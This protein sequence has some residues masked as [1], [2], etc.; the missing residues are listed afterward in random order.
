MVFTGHYSYLLCQGRSVLNFFWTG[1]N[2]FFVISGFVF[3]QQLNQKIYNLSFFTR[4]FFRIYP[5]YLLAL[6]SYYFLSGSEP[7]RFIYFVRHLLFMQTTSSIHE[8][9]FF[10]PA[11]W[12]LPVEIEFYILVPLLSF[13]NRRFSSLIYISIIPLL[14]LKILL[15]ANAQILPDANL[16]GILNAHLPGLILEFFL[17]VFLFRVYLFFKG[18]KV[19]T[20]VIILLQGIGLSLLFGLALFFARYGDE[21]LSRYL[22]LKAMFTILCDIGYCLVLFSCFFLLERQNRAFRAFCLFMGNISYSMYLFHHL[23]PRTFR[24]AG[25]QIEGVSAYAI[26]LILLLFLCILLHYMIE[27]PMRQLGRCI[28]ERIRRRTVDA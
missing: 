16:S 10:N 4:R 26:Y 21:G 12:S 22:L 14:C 23:I 27:D 13:V 3:A 1:V 20:S 8:A 18:R 5:L 28:S 25:I 24:K 15:V 2:L 17:G 6:V 9:F 19:S 11:F 7:G